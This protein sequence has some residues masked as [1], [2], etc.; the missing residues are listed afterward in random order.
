MPTGTP[1]LEHRVHAGRAEGKEERKAAAGAAR[2]TFL[3]SQT[4]VITHYIASICDNGR[5]L[6]KGG[7]R[8]GHRACQLAEDV[9]DATAEGYNAHQRQQGQGLPARQRHEGDGRGHGQVVEGDAPEGL[10]AALQPRATAGGGSF[11]VSNQLSYGMPSHC[12]TA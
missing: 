10:G 5:L 3:L 6:P 9:E 11:L 8:E 7:V 2:E 4:P 12:S 1:V